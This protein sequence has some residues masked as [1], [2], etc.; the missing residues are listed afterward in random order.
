M[1]G[2]HDTA[3]RRR[4]KRSGRERGCWAYIAAEQ[5]QAAGIDPGGPL[6][7]YRVVGI[8]KGRSRFVVQ[9]FE[10]GP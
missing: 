9:L 4:A 3:A 5:L 10:T 8:G 6:P 2:R 1:T 7:W